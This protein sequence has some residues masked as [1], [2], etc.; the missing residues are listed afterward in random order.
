M[1]L[2]LNDNIK[3]RTIMNKRIYIAPTIEI[4]TALTELYILAGSPKGTNIEGLGVSD[5]A[6]STEM[7]GRSR[8]GAW[9]WGDDDD[10]L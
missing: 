10:D 3:Q 8:Q 1:I 9:D 2:N 7:V 6:A 4:E 5:E